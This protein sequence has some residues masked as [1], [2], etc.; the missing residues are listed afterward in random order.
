MEEQPQPTAAEADANAPVAAGATGSPAPAATEVA[1]AAEVAAGEPEAAVEKGKEDDAEEAEPTAEPPAEEARKILHCRL[2]AA[3]AAWGA[4]KAAEA[5]AA[6]EQGKVD[7]VEVAKIAHQHRKVGVEEALVKVPEVERAIGEGKERGDHAFEI[8]AVTTETDSPLEADLKVRCRERP[9][10]YHSH[11]VWGQ[12]CT[13]LVSAGHG[14]T[15]E[16]ELLMEI[17][18]AP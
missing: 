14:G 5:A 15:V 10:V 8:E 4:L 18:N 16:E 13:F 6:P 1:A 7:A 9:Q 3:K 2:P 17:L 12:Q 11:S